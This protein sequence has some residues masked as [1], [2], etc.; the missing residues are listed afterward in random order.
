MV[1]LEEK[2]LAVS[3]CLNHGVPVQELSACGEPA[4][5][6]GYAQ[7][8]APK[9]ILELAGKPMDRMPFRHYSTISPVFSYTAIFPMRRT[10]R[11]SLL[12]GSCKKASISSVASSTE[13]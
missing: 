13:C 10:W 12:N 2:L 1:E 8:P 9:N 6:A 11:S 5:R 3:V 4:L 7:A